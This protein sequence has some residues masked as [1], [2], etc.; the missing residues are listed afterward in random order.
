MVEMT[1]Q[2]LEEM[3]APLSYRRSLFP[4]AFNGRVIP[5]ASLRTPRTLDAREA[6]LPVTRKTDRTAVKRVAELKAEISLADYARGV[7]S[8]AD[9]VSHK[10]SA[11]EKYQDVGR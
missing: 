5:P 11:T 10:N 8:F 4:G 1:L 6:E 3:G 9:Y 2:R 7:H